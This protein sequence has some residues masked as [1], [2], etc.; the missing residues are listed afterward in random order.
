M[1]KKNL[2]AKTSLFIS[3]ILA[4]LIFYRS[5]I[6]F[7][8]S[9][10]DYYF[11]YFVSIS[12]LIIISCSLFFINDEVQKNIISSVLGCLIV[13]YPLE[14]YL[15]YKK[16]KDHEYYNSYD[17]FKK[18][19]INYDKRSKFEVFKDLQ[20][21]YKNLATNTPPTLFTHSEDTFHLSGISNSPTLFCSEN[22][23]F[24][25]YQSDRYGFNNPDEIWDKKEI[26]YVLIG[27]SAVHGACVNYSDTL[28]GNLSRISNGNVLNL[29]M[30]GSGTL[31]EYAILREYLPKNIKRVLLFYYD[32]DLG[33]YDE[34]KSKILLNYF[35]DNSYSR[36]LKDKQNQIDAKLRTYVKNL[37]DNNDTK[38]NKHIIAIKN[39]ITFFNTRYYIASLFKPKN[40]RT[41]NLDYDIKNIKI[42]IKKIK[43]L[44]EENNAELYFIFLPDSKRYLDKKIHNDF[45]Q[46]IKENDNL[47]NMVEEL[48]IKMINLDEEIFKKVNDPFKYFSLGAKRIARHNNELGFKIIADKVFEKINEF[49]K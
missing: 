32:F 41:V 18:E 38:M 14:G 16:K 46:M 2:L 30:G 6:Q 13:L 7:Q 36:N 34:F 48:D 4:I 42:L 9:K 17:L 19:G 5:Q 3:I 15:I 35:K 21:Q 37:I 11:I 45:A 39:F 29:G 43:H 28:A 27:D 40:E 23:Y 1:Q 31:I 12:I 24:S 22:G 33:N 8:G 26:D 10:N 44:V 20:K 47:L 25:V 49:E